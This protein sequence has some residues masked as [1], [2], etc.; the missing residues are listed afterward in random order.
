MVASVQTPGAGGVGAYFTR[1]RGRQD[2]GCEVR[3]TEMRILI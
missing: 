3:E 1:V 2:G